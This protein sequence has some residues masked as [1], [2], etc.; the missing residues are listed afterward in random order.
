VSDLS[1]LLRRLHAERHAHFAPLRTTAWRICDAEAGAPCTVDWYDGAVVVHARAGGELPQE[2]EVANAIGISPNLVFRKERRRQTDR[3]HGGQ[4]QVVARAGAERVVSEHG[5][6]FA[7]NLSD[8]LDTGLFLDHR[9][10]RRL[11]GSAARGRSMLNLFAYT[12]A[13][14]VHA[15]AGGARTTVTVDL[16]NTY[17]RWAERN[18]AL[19]RLRGDHRMVKGDC[20]KLLAGHQTE[21]FDLI[22]CDPPTFSNSKAMARSWEVG[23]DHGWLL[24]RLYGLL[25]EGGT[26]WFSTNKTAFTLTSD[27]PPFATVADITPSTIDVDCAGT[28]PHR[29]WRMVR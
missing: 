24:T 11:I 23:R 2:A 4:Y 5:L 13:F 17:L 22:V 10:L 14:S 25:N 12:G 19:N 1:D 26:L 18:L 28:T 16:S 15:A 6:S 20:L 29:C 9:P 21:H 27:L 7:V 8:Y 3:Q